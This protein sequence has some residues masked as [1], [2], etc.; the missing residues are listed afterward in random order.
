MN[1]Y[2]GAGSGSYDNIFQ[3]YF[4]CSG[5]EESLAYCGRTL[6][7]YGYSH[8]YD[9]SI[10]CP[11]GLFTTLKDYTFT[12]TLYLK[13]IHLNYLTYITQLHNYA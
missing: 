7:Q 5:T 9:V 1:N 3:G 13:D 11:P 6:W 8:H 12:I 10:Y 2:Y 4:R